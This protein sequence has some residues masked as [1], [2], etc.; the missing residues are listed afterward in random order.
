MLNCINNDA[1]QIFPEMDTY[2]IS[3]RSKNI[4]S[5]KNK[6]A[7]RIPNY[8]DID[9]DQPYNM[10]LNYFSGKDIFLCCIFQ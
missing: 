3:F 1:L 7:N 10:L 8:M 4:F 9:F 6:I 5:C 2:S